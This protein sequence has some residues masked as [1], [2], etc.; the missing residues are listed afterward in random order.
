MKLT[1][2]E[3]EDLEFLYTIENDSEMWNVTNT[4]V[5]YSHYVLRD[6]I[7]NQQNDIYADKQLRLVIREDAHESSCKA[8]GLIDLFNFEPMHMRAEMGLAIVNA[9]QGK[10]YA[11][12][13][14]RQLKDYA[15]TTLHL[16][17]I[18]CIVPA[19]NLPS[20]AM[21]R[22]T[23]FTDEHTLKDW[24]LTVDG[25]KDAIHLQCFL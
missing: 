1:A 3:P 17:Q 20:L 23:G 11:T 13:A 15:L 25:W 4:N 6:Y 10:G 16:H 2:L 14:I 12:E 18:Y 19:D 22:A 9:A 21:L 7:A 24:I 8:I 5:P